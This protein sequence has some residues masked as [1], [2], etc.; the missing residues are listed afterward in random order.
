MSLALQ[1][2]AGFVSSGFLRKSR[3]MKEMTRGDRGKLLILFVPLFTLSLLSK[4]CV[5]PVAVLCL[6]AM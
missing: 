6:V 3:K 1:C 5:L 2:Y 4:D